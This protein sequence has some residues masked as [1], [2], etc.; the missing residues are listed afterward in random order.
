MTE[1]EGVEEVEVEVEVEV[2]SCG[3]V[4]YIPFLYAGI[5]CRVRK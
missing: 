3:I 2:I 4:I 1:A 5:F